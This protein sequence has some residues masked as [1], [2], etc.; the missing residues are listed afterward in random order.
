MECDSF[1]EYKSA[2]ERNDYETAKR[3]VHERF[4]YA[5]FING[6]S[7]ISETLRHG[8]LEWAKEFC[9]DYRMGIDGLVQL[10]LQIHCLSGNFE[11]AKAIYNLELLANRETESDEDWREIMLNDIEE[12]I[13]QLR[14]DGY[15]EIAEWLESVIPERRDDDD[16]DIC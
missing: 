1:K 6:Q 3:L 5:I 15:G 13:P 12:I 10:E 4:Q 2:C 11:I 16:D 9:R 8:H 14:E 7:V